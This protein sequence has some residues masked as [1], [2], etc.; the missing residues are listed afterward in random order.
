M[1]VVVVCRLTKMAHFIPCATT[2]MPGG[3]AELLKQNVFGGGGPGGGL[4]AAASAIAAAPPSSFLRLDLQVH[5][6]VLVFGVVV[7]VGAQSC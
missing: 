3:C 4:D 1:I 2:L 6:V 7:G 5:L